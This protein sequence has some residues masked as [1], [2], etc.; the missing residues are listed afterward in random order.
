MAYG[1]VMLTFKRDIVAIVKHIVCTGWVDVTW[2]SGGSNSYRM[3][4]EGKYDVKL[5]PSHNPDKLH[6]MAAYMK[7][8]SN[9]L[10]SHTNAKVSPCRMISIAYRL[11]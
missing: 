11:D 1:N 6:K 9:R 3:G 2:D 8:D 4:A 10:K 7:A 5:A